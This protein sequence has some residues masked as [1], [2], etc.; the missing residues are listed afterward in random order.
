MRW[1]LT[2]SCSHRLITDERKV[3]GLEFCPKCGMLHPVVACDEYEDREA[4]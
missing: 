4:G 1:M 3:Q 2:L